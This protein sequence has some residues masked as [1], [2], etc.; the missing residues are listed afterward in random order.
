M[1]SVFFKETQRYNKWE[2]MIRSIPMIMYMLPWRVFIL[3]TV[4]EITP[5]SVDWVACLPLMT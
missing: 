3:T 1:D 2:V 5:P 4:I